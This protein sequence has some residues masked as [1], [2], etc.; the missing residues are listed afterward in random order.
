MTAEAGGGREPGAETKTLRLRVVEALLE[1][2]RKGIVRV[3]Q[4]TFDGLGLILGEVVSVTGSRTTY[5]RLVPALSNQCTEDEV[6]L[7]G[8]ARE[9]AGTGLHGEVSLAKATYKD[10]GS[11]VLTPLGP[12]TTFHREGDVEFLKRYLVNLPVVTGDKVS[13]NLFGATEAS[14]R[15][16]GTAPSGPVLIT[17]RTLIHIQEPDVFEQSV[18]K[19]TYEDIGGLDREVRLVREIVEL[20]LKYPEVFRRLGIDPPKGILLYGPPG[21]GKTLI[22]RAVAGE[23]AVHFVHVNGPEIMNKY[24]GESEAKLREVFDEAR[25]KAPS[26]LFLDEIDALAP[27]RSEV[28]GDVEKRV[29]GQLLALM[30]GLVSRGQ[31]IVIGATNMPNLL[32]PA[33]RRPGRFDREIMV[34]VPDKVGRLDIFRIHTRGMALAGNVDLATLAGLTHG[35][36]GADLA[37]LCREAGMLALRKIAPALA[38]LESGPRDAFVADLK[39]EMRDFLAAAQEVKPSAT[40]EFF[41]ELP[42]VKWDDVGGLAEIKRRLTEVVSWPIK[43]P[44]RFAQFG[45]DP[46]RGVLFSGPSGT[47]KSLVARALARETGVSFLSIQ[48]PSLFS[49]WYGESERALRELFERAKQ[50]SPCILCLDELD[51]L[52]GRRG[53]QGSVAERMVSQLL[54]ELDALENSLKNV[55]VVGTTNRPD[56]ID[57]AFLRPGRFD[58]QIEFPLPGEGDRVEIF[59]VHLRGKPIAPD[60]DVAALAARSGGLTGADLHGVCR[61]AAFLALSQH[62]AGEGQG[63]KGTSAPSLTMQHLQDALEEVNQKRAAHRTNA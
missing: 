33:L 20:P 37:A 35:Y 45:V 14:L 46:V 34:P 36:V 62:L 24:Y 13:V 15:V 32:D 12:D 31:V 28:I 48:G 61:R 39:V 2:A 27:K 8:V 3:S 60:V 23:T 58:L 40:R 51:A 6:M 49:K 1:D 9:N 42:D 55:V 57:P 18:A 16:A 11:L 5:A 53:G 4:A 38:G 7:D 52:A 19:I 22:A 59:K 54:M 25:R 26:I 10:A 63:L 56:L 29:V 43:Y 47:G 30:D 50:A 17:S 21:T 41:T 44:E